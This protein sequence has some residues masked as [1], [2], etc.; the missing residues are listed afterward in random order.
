MTL[1]IKLFC[2]PKKACNGCFLDHIQVQNKL[3]FASMSSIYITQ[4]LGSYGFVITSFSLAYTDYTSTQ[5]LFLF[6]SNV[7]NFDDDHTISFLSVAWPISLMCHR[8]LRG[9]AHDPMDMAH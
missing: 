7:T 4:V 2:L 9:L 8:S 3:Y 6:H 5:F 1:D